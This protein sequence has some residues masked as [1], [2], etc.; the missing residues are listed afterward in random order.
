MTRPRE[1][2]G[3]Q[4]GLEAFGVGVRQPACGERAVAGAA[5]RARASPEKC[6]ATAP[7]AARVA[8]FVRY[9]GGVGRLSRRRCR[10]D[11]GPQTERDCREALPGAPTGFSSPV[12]SE[13]RGLVLG[14]GEHRHPRSNGSGG[15]DSV[16]IGR[17]GASRWVENEPRPLLRESIKWTRWTTSSRHRQGIFFQDEIAGRR[18]VTEPAAPP[19]TSSRSRPSTPDSRN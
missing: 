9:I 14:R 4:E 11:P 18:G 10:S 8:P 13:D 15:R 5:G 16:T 17:R 12:A 6:G 1:G 19:L 2:R 3:V 7:Y